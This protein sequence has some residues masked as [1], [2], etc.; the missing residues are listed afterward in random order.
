MLS[1]CK[2]LTDCKI[3]RLI[4]KFYFWLRVSLHATLL[5]SL[6]FNFRKTRVRK[7][8]IKTIHPTL[9]LWWWDFTHKTHSK[10]YAP[11]Y[12]EDSL[13]WHKSR[14]E[15]Y[16][17]AVLKFTFEEMISSFFLTDNFK[18]FMITYELIHSSKAI[19]VEF[20]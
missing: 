1:I 8:R 3:H 14:S 6:S 15:S 9:N 7:S 11:L 4:C 16:K 13:Y 2:A 18:L 20:M 10:R 19:I 17:Q 12:T 5:W